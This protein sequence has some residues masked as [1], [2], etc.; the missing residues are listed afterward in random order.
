[1][2]L[3]S[4]PEKQRGRQMQRNSCAL[5]LGTAL[6]ALQEKKQKQET[7]KSLLQKLCTNFRTAIITT[8]VTLVVQ[9]LSISLSKA[10]ASSNQGSLQKTFERKNTCTRV[11][12][13]TRSPVHGEIFP[14]Q[15]PADQNK[16]ATSRLP[17]IIQN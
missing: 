17:K 1:M 6:N 13:S 12:F 14:L 15:L 2:Q 11:N 10:L 4:V 7:A 5:I 3:R 8:L 9:R 16:T